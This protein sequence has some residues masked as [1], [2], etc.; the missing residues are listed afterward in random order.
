MTTKQK[1][2]EDANIIH[3][4]KPEDFPLPFQGV[5][6]YDPRFRQMKDDEIIDFLNIEEEWLS[7]GYNNFYIC[8]NLATVMIT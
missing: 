4:D 3:I 8:Q 5:E 6:Y 7:W 1:T 2:K